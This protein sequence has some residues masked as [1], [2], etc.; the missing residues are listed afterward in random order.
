MSKVVLEARVGGGESDQVGARAKCAEGRS[1]RVDGG[2][3]GGPCIF[4]NNREKVTATR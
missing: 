1:A 3:Q 2:L 4:S